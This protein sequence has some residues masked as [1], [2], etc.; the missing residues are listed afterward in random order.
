MISE[1]HLEYKKRQ[2]RENGLFLEMFI[3]VKRMLFKILINLIV[4]KFQFT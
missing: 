4:V 1:G 2:Y 3:F